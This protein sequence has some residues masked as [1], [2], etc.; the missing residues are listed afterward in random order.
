MSENYLNRGDAPFSE[1]VWAKI[2]EAAVGAAKS[3]L[4]ARRVLH[5][6]GPYGLGFKL[7]PGADQAVAE[8]EG[9]VKLVASTA[10]PLAGIHAAFA[11]SARDVAA[12]DQ[13]GLPFDLGPVARA[14]IACAR[15]E[16]DVVYNGS[17]AVGA[18]GLLT[19]KGTQSVGLASWSKIGAA[20]DDIIKAVTKLDDAGFHGPYTLAL[21]PALYNLLLRR[22]PQGFQSELEHIQTIVTEGVVKAAAL[23]DGGVLIASGPQYATIVLG[24]DLAVGFVGPR[25]R[26]YE[27]TVSES[28]ALRLIEPAAVCVLK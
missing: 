28:L 24:Q 15:Q 11:L 7:L 19:A 3:Q 26:E 25:D 23:K 18:A 20:A 6:E 12:Y 14:A 9:G 2:D 4:S 17:R 21:A 10:V 5:I 13:T 1:K 27:L 16:D 8:S 22:Y